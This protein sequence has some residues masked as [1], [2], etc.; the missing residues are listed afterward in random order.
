V[1][2]EPMPQWAGKDHA[3]HQEDVRRPPGGHQEIPLLLRP[4]EQRLAQA[5]PL[6]AKGEDEPRP[7]PGPPP[8][9]GV[10]TKHKKSAEKEREEV[11][12]G[13]HEE[14]EGEGSSKTGE[15]GLASQSSQ[16]GPTP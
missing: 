4:A 6:G 10:A 16:G 12:Q 7:R 14:E 3:E 15:S 13:D 8:P 9:H 1:P 2:A 5:P 11:L